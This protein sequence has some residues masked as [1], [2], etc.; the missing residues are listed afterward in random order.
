MPRHYYP[1]LLGNEFDAERKDLSINYSSEPYKPSQLEPVTSLGDII[2]LKDVISEDL[3]YW[4]YKLKNG[5]GTIAVNADYSKA[6]IH[7]QKELAYFGRE[8]LSEIFGK[9]IQII[10][11]CKLTRDGFLVLHSACVEKDGSAYAFT[12]P[13][14]IGKSTRAAKWC[15]LLSSELIS[16]DRPAI[17]VAEKTA[18]G[19]PWDG[20]EGIYRN[21]HFPL[22]AILI[23]KRTELPQVKELSENEKTQILSQQ[24]SV[25]MWDP[26]LAAKA[27]NSL[28]KLIRYV[29]VYEHCG[30]IDNQTILQSYETLCEVIYKKESINNEN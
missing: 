27:L 16:G 11:E 23:V 7:F 13:S 9:Y 17:N 28:K 14:G 25:P 21:V 3:Y 30:G 29:P 26:A 15:E 12:G 20:K 18:W 2:I 1:F 4:V 10:L 5:S 19:V 6:T 22:A 8:N 24:I